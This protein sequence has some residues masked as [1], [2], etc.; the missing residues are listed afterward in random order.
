MSAFIVVSLVF[1]SDLPTCERK[2]IARF[3]A[4][5]KHHLF[6]LDLVVTNISNTG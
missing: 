2:P 1:N 5:E 6:F 3:F 4:R